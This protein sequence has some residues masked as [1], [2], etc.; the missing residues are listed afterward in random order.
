MNAR[1]HLVL[2]ALCAATSAC[3]AIGGGERTN[4]LAK[5]GSLSFALP[6]DWQRTDS[7]VGDAVT[8]VWTPPG[9]NDAKESVT[10]IRIER[11]A[12]KVGDTPLDLL[13]SGAQGALQDARISHRETISTPQGFAGARLRV[14][15]KPAGQDRVYRRV[16]A[17]LRDGTALVHVL[18]TAA[19]PDETFEVFHTVL[20]TI[21]REEG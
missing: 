16:H 18:Y 20:E 14:A 11:A 2:V 9:A 12:Q 4:Q 5:L 17:T 10:I 19:E 8:S 13:L 21:R 1:N 6:D 15:F 3:G 7:A